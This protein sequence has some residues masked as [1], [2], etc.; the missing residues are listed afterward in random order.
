MEERK[1]S[2]G[3]SFSKC[4]FY[5]LKFTILYVLCE[6]TLAFSKKIIYLFI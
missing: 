2:L 6:K 4:F 5:L 1:P 3:V